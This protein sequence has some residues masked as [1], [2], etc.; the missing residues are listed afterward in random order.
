MSRR[1]ASNQPLQQTAPAILV[2]GIN[3]LS[4]AMSRLDEYTICKI[5]VQ[6]NWV[7]DDE[8]SAAEVA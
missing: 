5:G 8:G 2:C 3:C 4:A 6:N 7:A 1:G